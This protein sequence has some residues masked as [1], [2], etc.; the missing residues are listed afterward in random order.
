MCGIAGFLAAGRPEARR[1]QLQRMVATLRHRG[2][3]D[4]GVH[5]DDAVALGV[6][7]LA[8]IDVATGHQ[9][10]TG[11]DGSV[12]V[13]LNGEI[14][15][16]RELRAELEARG[17]RFRTRSDT[18]VVAH[19]YEEHG[20]ACVQR[21]DGM[22]ALAIWD[23]EQ[24]ALFLARDRMGE[25]P[26]HYF[27]APGVFVFGSEIRALLAHSAVPRRLSLPGLA[28]YLAFEYVPTSASILDGIVT[29]PP[30]HLLRVAPEQ[31]P[32]TDGY[33]DLAFTPEPDVSERE[34]RRRVW[35]ALE[36]SVERR[37][38]SEV[39]VG[40]FLSGG[41]DSSAVVALAA[42]LRPGQRL[43]TFA[44]GFADTPYDERRFARMV[45]ERHGTVHEEV[46]FTGDDARALMDRVGDLLDTPLADSSFLPTYALSRHARR[47]VTVALSGDGGDELFC[48]Y[49]TFQ[50]DRL[51]RWLRRLP[52]AWLRPLA[53]AARPGARSTAYGDVR[54]LLGQFLRG[55]PHPPAIRTQLL[56]GGLTAD[57]RA[58]LLSPAARDGAGPAD[59]HDELLALVPPGIVGRLDALIYQHC[60][61]YLAAQNLVNVDR[62]SMACGLEVRAPFLDHQLV[63]LLG[64]MPA[65]LKLRG[66]RT[67]YVLRETLRD[68]LPAAVL[69][70][71][72]QGFGAPTAAWLRGPLRDVLEARLAPDRLRAT[73]LFDVSTVRRLVGEHVSGRRDH[74]RVLWSLL[75]FESWREHYLGPT[76]AA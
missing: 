68:V 33:W 48:G 39:P 12:H 38:D 36:S 35:T 63:E 31:E 72:K 13:V 22:F 14:Y 7:R 26:L 57:E 24:Q 6:R 66:T 46:E 29:L 34:W 25:K 75:M 65:S 61:G 15:N 45:A 60:K 27:A 56:L 42:G 41:I 40:F 32:K 9:P 62:A 3:D 2:P 4:E 54:T 53:R 76:S 16:H 50:V 47:S 44:L 73:G 51:A 21:L 19:A 71:R 49:P 17:H 8:I 30:G 18:E 11:E 37:L 55:V 20:P 64:R 10:I 43:R 5:V 28:A 59:P 67:K 52:E 23:A 58:D 69:E 70:R 74:R 1:A